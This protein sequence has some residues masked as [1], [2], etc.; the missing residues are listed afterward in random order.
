[1]IRSIVHAACAGESAS[2]AGSRGGRRQR[3]RR[4]IRWTQT[5]Q[6]FQRR[7]TRRLP[8]R[9]LSGVDFVAAREQASKNLPSEGEGDAMIAS[10]AMILAMLIPVGFAVAFVA[11]AT[12]R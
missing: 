11:E 3:R 9:A 7:R 8:F 10:L 2:G 6:T 1:S 12:A 4:K 5:A